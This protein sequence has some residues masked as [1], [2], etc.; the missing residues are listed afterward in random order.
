[1]SSQ[2]EI[3]ARL[4]RIKGLWL[5]LEQIKPTM[6]MYKE[7]MKE[8][9]AESLVYQALLNAQYDLE[10]RQNDVDRRQIDRRRIVRRNK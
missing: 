5:E 8:I 2:N 10:R 4:E 3:T 1:M 7:L 9:H 6:P